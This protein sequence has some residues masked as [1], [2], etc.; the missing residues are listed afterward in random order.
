MNYEIANECAT[1]SDQEK[2]T[3]PEI[4]QRLMKADIELY[5]ADL[6]QSNKTF[7]SGD[8][9]HTVKCLK[10]HDKVSPSFNLD[11]VVKAIKQIQFGEIKYQEFVK[12]IMDSGILCYMVFI[13]GRKAIYFGRNGEQHIE[14][15]PK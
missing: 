8:T 14:H 4:V 10:K 3:F 1:L 12:K 11:G 5:Y 2:I 6:L 15:F 7:Y 9:T 13:T